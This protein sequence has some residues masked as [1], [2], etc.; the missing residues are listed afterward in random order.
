MRWVIISI[1]AALVVFGVVL[2]E[3]FPQVLDSYPHLQETSWKIRD[4][5]G[6]EINDPAYE[7]YRMY[8][9]S[10]VMFKKE[11]TLQ[12]QIE[13]CGPLPK[14]P[15]AVSDLPTKEDIEQYFKKKAAWE[16]CTERK[17]LASFKNS[18]GSAKKK[19]IKIKEYRD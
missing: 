18:R 1:S 7:E 9:E 8:E 6:M 2:T 15:W 10:E 16:R 14:N 17:K 12:Q 19:K 5:L 4:R 13:A 11:N 3:Y